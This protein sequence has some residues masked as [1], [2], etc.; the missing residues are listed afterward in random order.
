[1]GLLSDWRAGALGQRIRRLFEPP[2][3][4]AD[5][6]R[7]AE[8]GRQ[9]RRILEPVARE[10]GVDYDRSYMTAPR[11]DAELVMNAMFCGSDLLEPF[12]SVESWPVDDFGRGTSKPEAQSA[13][14]H[15]KE[16]LRRGEG[17]DATSVMAQGYGRALA[18]TWRSSAPMDEHRDVADQL[19]ESALA[20]DGLAELVAATW[21]ARG[22]EAVLE[23]VAQADAQRMFEIDNPDAMADLR[24]YA[25]QTRAI[26]E[27]LAVAMSARFDEFADAILGPVYQVHPGYMIVQQTR[28][29]AKASSW[30]NLL[31]AEPVSQREVGQAYMER[32][33]RGEFDPPQA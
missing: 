13:A 8:V 10:L 1:M 9:S 16:A 29:T 23:R 3:K 32:A 15:L 33:A 4:L 18:A 22:Y 14:D 31:R 19:R 20:S 11:S 30:S 2:L 6:D 25:R 21:P 28:W 17:R 7:A 26:A 5:Y 24:A 27:A 12:A